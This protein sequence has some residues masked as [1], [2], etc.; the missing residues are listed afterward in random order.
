MSAPVCSAAVLHI[1][2][3][4]LGFNSGWSVWHY[5]VFISGTLI[6]KEKLAGCQDGVHYYVAK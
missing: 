3:R 6:G 1:V 2:Y 4:V 5:M